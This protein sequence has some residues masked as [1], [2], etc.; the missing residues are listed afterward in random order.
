MIILSTQS[1][2]VSIA[3]NRLRVNPLNVGST[4]KSKARLSQT[5]LLSSPLLFPGH[6]SAESVSERAS[7]VAHAVSRPQSM[8]MVA[9]PG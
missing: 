7:L 4:G 3:V 6:D 2:T 9:F 8:A 5:V 1:A